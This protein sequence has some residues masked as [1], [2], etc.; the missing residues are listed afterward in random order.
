MAQAH[1]A[2]RVEHERKMCL[3]C[4]YRGRILQGERGLITFQCPSCGCDLYARP[5]RSYAELEGFVVPEPA[6]PPA[7]TIPTPPP[8]RAARGRTRRGVI[9][10]RLL[11]WSIAVILAIA[12]FGG[13]A[14]ALI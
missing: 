10:E 14:A 11:A 13:L 12:I 1:K 5:P 3:S 9:L 4:G 7:L 8:S 2:I 6:R